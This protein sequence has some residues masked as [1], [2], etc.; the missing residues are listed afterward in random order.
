M[1]PST[2]GGRAAPV[3]DA[4]LFDAVLFP[5]RSLS[6]AGFALLMGAVSAVAFA[7][8][9]MFW[10]VGAWPVFG[11]LGLDVLLI[12][13]AFRLNYRAARRYE[14]VRLD[15]GELVV[16]RVDRKGAR[17]RVALPA[18]WLRVA[19]L[20]EGAGQGRLVLSTHG[21]SVEIGS[22]L[23]LAEKE[24]FAA[25]LGGALARLRMAEHLR[26]E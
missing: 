16:E 22:F 18:Y 17:Q 1:D 9:V 19:V 14:T 3:G 7:A 11:F 12:Y 15:A 4:A 8:G 5:H 25:A 24:G 2:D 21:Q 10:V 23:S 20:E 26:P 13:I 6:R